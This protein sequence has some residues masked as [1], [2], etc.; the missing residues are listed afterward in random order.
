MLFSTLLSKALFYPGRLW[1][2]LAEDQFFIIIIIVA[3]YENLTAS[4]GHVTVAHSPL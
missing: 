4:C 3:L 2:K 1:V